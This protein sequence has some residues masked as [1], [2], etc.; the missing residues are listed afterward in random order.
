[1]SQ[2]SQLVKQMIDEKVRQLLAEQGIGLY[3]D[4]SNAEAFL[5]EFGDDLLY[6]AEMQRWMI[7]SSGVWMPDRDHT[8]YALA[9]DFVKTFYAEAAGEAAV[10]A[11]RRANMRSAIESMLSLAGKRK[12]VSI[13]SFDVD[14]YLLNCKN[15]VVDLRSGKLIPHDRSLRISRKI[16]FNYDPSA[17]SP[18]F[19]RFL[20]DI[21]PDPAIRAFLQRSIG[22]SL[23]GVARE[24]AFWILYG[25]GNNGKSIFTNLFLK[26]LGGYAAGATTATIM[27]TRQHSIPNDIARLKGRRF[28]VIPE[29]DENEM[30][31][32][33][34]IKALSAG[35]QLTARFLFGEFFD[36]FFAGKLWIA[37]NHKPKIF[38]NSKGFWDRIKVV[39]FTV[40]IPSE[41]LIKS[42]DLLG[43]LLAEGDGILAWAVQGAR[44]YFEI[45]GLDT[46][47]AI[48]AEIERY[49]R[50]QDSILQFIE[51]CCETAEDLRKLFPD[52][53]IPDEIIVTQNGD[54][55]N[56]YKKFCYEN[57]EHPKSH[58]RLSLKLH[59]KGFKQS[60]ANGIPRTWLGIRLKP[61]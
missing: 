42:D 53:H 25:T 7:W 39:P 11:A 30:L 44:D 27:Q 48:T 60:R 55:Y 34:L 49:R 20:R 36:F 24:R 22:Y 14:P 3:D 45:D 35:D 18:V 15:G 8:V 46:P 21:Q 29:T 16:D 41:Q 47:P 4:V 57:G 17:R 54:L 13:D 40:D 2:P 52:E 61:G 59:E 38:D 31:N 51:E 12:T 5:R 50:E 23:L 26:L 37:T 10:R 6:C 56:A 9:M 32:A 28:I 33:S 58:R 19:E 1:M 43:Q